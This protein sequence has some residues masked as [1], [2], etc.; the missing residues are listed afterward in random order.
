MLYLLN[1]GSELDSVR[2]KLNSCSYT[3][4]TNKLI[5]IHLQKDVCNGFRE[6]NLV[7]YNHTFKNL[8][9]S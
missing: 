1:L 7:K 3:I 9:I 4:Q 5:S 6:Y 8:D 2:E